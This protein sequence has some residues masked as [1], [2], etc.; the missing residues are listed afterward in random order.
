[1]D[2]AYFVKFVNCKMRV[3]EKYVCVVVRSIERSS[4]QIN[5]FLRVVHVLQ[6]LFETLFAWARFCGNILFGHILDILRVT[7]I[8]YEDDNGT[9]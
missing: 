9:P 8:N 1:M 3:R 4:E 6:I 7:L 2:D 5:K